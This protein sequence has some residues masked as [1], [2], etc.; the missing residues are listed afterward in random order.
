MV[1]L[2][3]VIMPTAGNIIMVMCGLMIG[4]V[5][6][7]TAWLAAVPGGKLYMPPVGAR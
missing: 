1:P 3:G 6:Q 2:P 5:V 7:L 4:L